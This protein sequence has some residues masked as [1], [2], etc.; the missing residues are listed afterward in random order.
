MWSQLNQ[1]AQFLDAGVSQEYQ[2][3]T[4]N[5]EIDW[6]ISIGNYLLDIFKDFFDPITFSLKEAITT[7]CSKTC[8]FVTNPF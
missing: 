7:L 8:V 4:S 2:L 5:S 3:A 1:I 6:C